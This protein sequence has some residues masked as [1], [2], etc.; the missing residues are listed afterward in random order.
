MYRLCV[1]VALCCALGS[2]CFAAPKTRDEAPKSQHER[3]AEQNDLPH[4]ESDGHENLLSKVRTRSFPFVVLLSH[5]S[6]VR[7]QQ[8][9]T[10]LNERAGKHIRPLCLCS[11]WVIMT[12]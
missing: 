11:C 7:K 12:K 10:F 1:I 6:L 4:E 2:R 9:Q 8:F 5:N 3:D